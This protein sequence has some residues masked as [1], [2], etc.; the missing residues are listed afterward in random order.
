MRALSACDCGVLRPS[1]AVRGG[2]GGGSGGGTGGGEPPAG[3]DA[4]TADFE[5]GFSGGNLPRSRLRGGGV[6]GCERSLSD[7]EL[8]VVVAGTFTR[9]ETPTWRVT[10]D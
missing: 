5:A 8:P 9:T 1:R 7:I 4:V 3:R 10:V 6:G 2:G